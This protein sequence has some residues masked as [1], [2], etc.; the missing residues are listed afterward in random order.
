MTFTN[1]A[2]VILEQ[3]G[4]RQPMHYRDI[5]NQI[6]EQDLVHT[7]GQTPEATLYASIGSEIKRN[8]RR[9]ET[10][11]FVMHGKGYV[12]LRKWMGEG[13]AFQIKQHNA[14]VRKKLLARLRKMQWA[15]FEALVAQLLVAM[16]QLY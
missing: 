5:T 7:E 1:A 6:L 9:G 13:L 8:L 2:E 11:R 3:C 4:D 15:D 16:G 10:P 14:E 12:G